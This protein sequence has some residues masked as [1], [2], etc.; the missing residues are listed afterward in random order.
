MTFLR[1]ELKRFAYKLQMRTKLPED[2]KTKMK[3]FLSI[4]D[5]S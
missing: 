3:N 2:H 5:E 1:K 4:V